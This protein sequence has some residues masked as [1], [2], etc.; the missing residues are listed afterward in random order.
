MLTDDWVN[1]CSKKA[2]CLYS[3][4]SACFRAAMLREIPASATN[5]PDASRSAVMRVSAA[6]KWPSL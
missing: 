4:A 5:R 1:I 3:S 6:T 2:F